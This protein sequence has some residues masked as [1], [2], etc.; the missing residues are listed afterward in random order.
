MGGVP[1]LIQA[2]DMVNTIPDEKVTV[3]FLAYFASRL[4]EL[5]VEMDAAKKIQSAWKSY[6]MFRAERQI[7]EKYSS[8][9]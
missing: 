3:T 4:M 9:M 2:S 8:K 5:S 6:K 1:L 7:R